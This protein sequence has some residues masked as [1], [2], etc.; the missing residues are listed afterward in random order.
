MRISPSL[1]FENHALDS[2]MKFPGN[3]VWKWNWNRFRPN[4]WILW[5]CIQRDL[6]LESMVSNWWSYFVSTSKWRKGRKDLFWVDWIVDCKRNLWLK[7]CWFTSFNIVFR[8]IAWK[9]T[10]FSWFLK[11]QW[12]IIQNS[13][14]FERDCLTKKQDHLKR[15][16]WSR[17]QATLDSRTLD[18][19][20][21][22]SW[23]SLSLICNPRHKLWPLSWRSFQKRHYWKRRRISW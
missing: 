16:N 3:W 17:I 22:E 15:L 5:T 9:T 6:K 2:K 23:R 12:W 11:D 7:T 4:S 19:K 8:F 21:N 14:R 10:N 13:C 20:W 1:C 18:E